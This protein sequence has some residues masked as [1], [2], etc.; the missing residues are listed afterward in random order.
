MS[1]TSIKNGFWS[2]HFREIAT[3]PR[4]TRPPIDGMADREPRLLAMLSLAAGES[5]FWK[6]SRLL[7][8]IVDLAALVLRR[9][10]DPGPA[11]SLLA[12]SPSGLLPIWGERRHDRG[13]CRFIGLS[14]WSFRR[15]RPSRISTPMPGWSPS[16]PPPGWR[17]RSF[18]V[19]CAI[20]IFINPRNWPTACR[21]STTRVRPRRWLR[22]CHGRDQCA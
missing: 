16:S 2:R 7:A 22:A 13:C 15:H 19:G 6:P 12:S 17:R 14:G 9:R 20:C 21:L 10:R 8:L 5:R 1:T 3:K 4:L 18:S 11:A